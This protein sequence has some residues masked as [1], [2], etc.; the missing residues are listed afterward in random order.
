MRKDVLEEIL[1]CPSLPSLPAVAVRVIELTSDPNV[2]LSDLGEMIETD[3]GLTTKIL[4][5]VNSSYY[6][7]RQKCANIQKALVMLGLN[8]VKSLALSFSL[9]SAVQDGES[10]GEFDFVS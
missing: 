8:P 10:E 6:G 3:Q 1:S 7:L 5:T 2:R 9:V 4:R